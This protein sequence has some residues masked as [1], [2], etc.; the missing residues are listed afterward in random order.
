MKALIVEDETLAAQNL[1][2]ILY[3]IGSFDS[4]NILDSIKETVEFLKGND[5]PDILFLDIHLADGSAFEIFDKIQVDCPVVFV[6]AY[7]EH[8]LKAFRLTSIDYL[9]KPLDIFDVKRAIDKLKRLNRASGMHENE[10]KNLISYFKREVEYK[11]HFL[12]NLEDDKLF[13]LKTEDIAFLYSSH[14]IVLAFTNDGKTFTMDQSMDQIEGM[15]D[16]GI[17]FRANSR[18]IISRKAVRDLGFWFSRRHSVNLKVRTPEKIVVS[19][20]KVTQFKSW[21]EESI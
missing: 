9:L 10:L 13:P 18:F 11:S 20:E 3:D 8:A 16:P 2:K 7:N 14:D 15:L 5:K 17:F 4:I 6:T 1:A 21:V 19:I 12:I